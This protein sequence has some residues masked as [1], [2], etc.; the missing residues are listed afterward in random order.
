[1]TTSCT[2]LLWKALN[3]YID[4]ILEPKILLVNAV[5]NAGI[6]QPMWSNGKRFSIAYDVRLLFL[7]SR[8]NSHLK[9]RSNFAPLFCLLS[10]LSVVIFRG[11]NSGKLEVKSISNGV[12]QI[13]THYLCRL[14]ERNMTTKDAYQYFV[15]RAQGL[16]IQ[17]NWIPVNWCDILPSRN[18]WIT[19][20]IASKY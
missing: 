3:F 12:F 14:Q 2:K 13:L 8:S 10:V 19:E 15:L 18:R 20:I 17:L 11:K 1:M 7:A 6:R 5:Q 4:E 16:A 9:C